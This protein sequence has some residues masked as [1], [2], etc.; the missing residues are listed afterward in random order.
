MIGL[1]VKASQSVDKQSHVPGLYI[2]TLT[3]SVNLENHFKRTRFR[4]TGPRSLCIEGVL[5]PSSLQNLALISRLS[6]YFLSA[7]HINFLLLRKLIL[8]SQELM[9]C[10]LIILLYYLLPRFFS[11]LPAPCTF[12]IMIPIPWLF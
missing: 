4:L 7:P 1:W 5:A 2:N 8:L 10:S 12:P 11:L 6:N 3:L 9:G